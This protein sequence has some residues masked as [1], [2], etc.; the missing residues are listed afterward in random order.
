MARYLLTSPDYYLPKYLPNQTSS[1]SCIR[2]IIGI[3]LLF[4]NNKCLSRD[5]LDKNIAEQS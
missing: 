5:P 2:G 4:L 3:N 1:F